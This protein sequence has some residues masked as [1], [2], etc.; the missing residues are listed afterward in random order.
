MINIYP[1]FAYGQSKMFFISKKGVFKVPIP[2]FILDKNNINPTSK[3]LKIY[4]FF[5]FF[6]FRQKTWKRVRKTISPSGQN[7][8]RD[9]ASLVPG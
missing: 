3:K 7:L 4:D 1:T 8:T 5:L 6:M 2:I 9:L